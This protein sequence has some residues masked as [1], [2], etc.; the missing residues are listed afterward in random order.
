MNAILQP[1]YGSP[2]V[3]RLATV[4]D[5]EV[6]P[7]T[8]R[9]RVV[10][11]SLNKGD[12]HLLTGTP[13]P[14]R[15]AGYGFARPVQPI[16]GQAIAGRV[17][18]VGAGVTGWAAGDEVYAQVNRGGFAEL[19]LARPDELARKPASASFEEA[20]AIP[21]AGTTALQ[22][23]RDAGALKAGESVLINGAA[24]GVGTFAVQIAKAMGATVTAVCSSR[25][26]ELVRS[27]GADRVIAYDQEDFADGV[28]RHDVIFDLV[29]NRPVAALRALLRPGGR[30]VASGGGAD[31]AWTGPMGAVIGGLVSNAWSSSRFVSLLGKASAADLTTLAG[32][33]D[34][35]TVRVVIDRRWSL[36]EAADA[37]RYLGEGRSRGKSVLSV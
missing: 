27:L 2:D 4:P 12:W 8:V 13:Y 29:G 5:P 1:A 28:A 22:G 35:G 18:A 34:A 30:L 15:L 31:N 25:N 3:L 7:G 16:P 26:V 36:G 37:M 20:A 9:V 11:A 6:A 23:L 19:V 32:M 14:V 10:A 21:I 33:V 17:E 24:G